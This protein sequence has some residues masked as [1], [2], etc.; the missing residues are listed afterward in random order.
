MLALCLGIP[1]FVNLNAETFEKSTANLSMTT[2]EEESSKPEGLIAKNKQC[3]KRGPRG[4]HGRRGPHGK[5]RVVAFASGTLVTTSLPGV[6]VSAGNNVPFNTINVKNFKYN[7]TTKVFTSQVGKGYYQV[8]FAGLF[9]VLINPRIQLFVDGAPLTPTGTG[10]IRNSLGWGSESIIV[11][12][13]K[14]KPNF[15]IRCPVN[16]VFLGNLNSIPGDSASI[17]IV[18]IG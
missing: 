14:K 1:N 9:G 7:S 16:T 4:H 5:R 10:V 15:E 18:K 17:T 3:C 11:Y 2:C 6:T 13:G 12:S 8:N